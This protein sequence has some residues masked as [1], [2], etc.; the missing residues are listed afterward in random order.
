ME[1]NVLA[2]KLLN[3]FDLNSANMFWNMWDV[4]SIFLVIYN[5]RLITNIDYWLSVF[6]TV[7]YISML[8]SSP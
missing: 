1:W 2:I 8:E 3:D 4:S 6:E 7:Y 5:L